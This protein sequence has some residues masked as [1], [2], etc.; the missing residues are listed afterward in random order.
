MGP[1]S[2]LFDLLCVVHSAADILSRA[3]AIQARQATIAFRRPAVSPNTTGNA[4]GARAGA[5]DRAFEEST[6]SVNNPSENITPSVLRAKLV[7]SSA[8]EPTVRTPNDWAPM[9]DSSGSV[10]L[11][12]PVDSTRHASA[13][14]AAEPQKESV[15]KSSPV[16]VEEVIIPFRA[17][18][19]PAESGV[20]GSSPDV[21]Q[22]NPTPKSLEDVPEVSHVFWY[23]VMSGKLICHT[24][25]CCPAESV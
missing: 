5:R 2:G 20:H 4:A 7:A 17:P 19:P 1:R 13:L 22:A 25:A 12:E 3:A 23:G 21:I 10:V 8:P 14:A 11:D 18:L 24:V 6:G 15:V 9:G 16:V